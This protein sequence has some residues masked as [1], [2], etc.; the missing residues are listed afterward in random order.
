MATSLCKYILLACI[1]HIKFELQ[2]FFL[3]VLK[4][5]FRFSSLKN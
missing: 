2:V 5:K 4:K 1:I 3:I